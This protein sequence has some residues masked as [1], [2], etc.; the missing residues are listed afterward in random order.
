[1]INKKYKK[2]LFFI[3]L[4]FLFLGIVNAT[5]V[6]SNE[7]LVK[8]HD[9][10]MTNDEIFLIEDTYSHKT[11]DEKLDITDDTQNINEKQALIEVDEISETQYYDPVSISGNLKDSNGNSL[12]NSSL[13]ININGKD[14]QTNTNI[15]GLF[16]YNTKATVIGK[17]NVSVTFTGDSYNT[18]TSTKVNYNVIAKDTKVIINSIANTEYTDYALISGR[19][20]DKDNNALRYTNMLLDING[21]KN[22]VKTDVNGYYN[23]SY[24]TGKIGL[25]N[26][27]VS[28]K[29]NE[30]YKSA[31]TKVTFTVTK[32]STVMILDN[33]KNTQ[34]TDNVVLSGKYTDNNGYRLRYTP[35]TINI[36][37]EKFTTTTDA[38]G[39]YNYTYK[40]SKVGKNNVTVSYPGN[41][42]YNGTDIS[43]TFN[44][45]RKST[46]ITLNKIQ[47]T[48][49]G[50]NVVISGKYTDNNGY[51]LRY[52][53]ITININSEKFTTNTDGNG[54][55]N[56][57]YKTTKVGK[58]NVTASYPGNTR[59]QGSSIKSTFNVINSVN[60]IIDTPQKA[61]NGSNVD[62]RVYVTYKESD[63]LKTI[64][65]GSVKVKINN[66]TL[67]SN[68]K[69]GKAIIAYKLPSKIGNYSISASY[70][71]DNYMGS[72]KKNIVLTNG[73]ISSSESAILG[74]KDPKTDVI[75]LTNGVPN[76]V[77]M[78][79][80][81]WADE[82]GTY[83]LSKSQIEEVFKQDSYSLYLN[84]H[85]SKYVAFKTLNESNIY[86][87]LKREKWNVI[88]KAVNKQRVKTSKGTTP[89]NITVNLKGKSYTYGE[90][91]A[92][93][94]TEYTCG[95]TATS[96]CT[97]S[98]RNYVNEHT[99][100]VDFKTYTYT[101]TYAKYVPGAMKKHNMT[102]E[103]IYKNTFNSALD[104]LSKGGCSIVFYG[105]NHYVS[106]IDISKDKTKVLVSN[107]YGN[108]SLGGGKIPNGW[109]SVS[110]MKQKFSKDSFAGLLIQLDYS[111]SSSTKTR[112]NNLY[113]NFGTNWNRQNTNEELNV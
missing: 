110:L 107:S 47:D 57:T 22:Y 74:N 32:K 29:G 38:N 11:D 16:K 53:P 49:N 3:M 9:S 101:G 40:T 106:I 99:L 83:T 98:L 104:K 92:K 69:Y 19:Y 54:Y 87:V 23:Y 28:Y 79:N 39:Y 55:Y 75:S 17:N 94:S 43:K 50:A 109:V 71:S 15:N 2:V 59:Y 63:I 7:T 8:E 108:Y 34:Y 13:N 95:P 91:R 67:T 78:T 30:R 88:E 77:Y 36:N 25:N 93:Q 60:V 46:K 72:S 113:N 21:A 105:V 80:Y 18:K 35:I 27:S 112:V 64:N 76:L 61:K 85:M 97:Q 12:S 1:M 24:K 4:I 111:L 48:N 58:N 51:R 65:D 81:V 82:N 86:H 73:Q 84:K 66:Q 5:D 90:A 20:V 103:Y 41:T 62:I 56:L 14:Y 100:A 68:V 96:V 42:R 26:L 6:D 45:T 89:N 102:A 52:T 70:T 31:I 44:V 37:S 33:I 10:S